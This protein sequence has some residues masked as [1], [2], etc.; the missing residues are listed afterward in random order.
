[1]CSYP[2]TKV[3][4]EG[5]ASANCSRRQIRDVAKPTRRQAAEIIVKSTTS[6]TLSILSAAFRPV[7]ETVSD[8]VGGHRALCRRLHRI[9]SRSSVAVLRI[10]G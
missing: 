9:V 7:L 4:L 1:M 2:Q 10:R 3:R 8:A 5:Q 6:H